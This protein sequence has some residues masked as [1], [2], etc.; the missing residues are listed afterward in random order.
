MQ[1]QPTGQ[2]LIKDPDSFGG[3]SNTESRLDG[4][5][6]HSIQVENY[7]EMIATRLCN[8]LPLQDKHGIRARGREET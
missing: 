4:L 1:T 2:G 5:D 8:D 3:K 6:N 7:L